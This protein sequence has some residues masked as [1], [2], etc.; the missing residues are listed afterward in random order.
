LVLLHYIDATEPSSSEVILGFL[1]PDADALIERALAAGGAVVREPTLH[2]DIGVKV[3][4][5]T[6]IENHLIEVVQPVR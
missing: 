6:D 4:F 5:I 2:A 3:G 1:T